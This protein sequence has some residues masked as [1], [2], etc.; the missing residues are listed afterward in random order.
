MAKTAN[1]KT[2]SGKRANKRA[3]GEVARDEMASIELVGAVRDDY[4]LTPAEA[5]RLPVSYLRSLVELPG[6][7]IPE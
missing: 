4:P 5:S 6:D 1:G 2:A 7:E 3:P